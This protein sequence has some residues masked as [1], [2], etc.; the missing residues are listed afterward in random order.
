MSRGDDEIIAVPVASHPLARKRK[1]GA[2]ALLATE[3]VML[4]E[5][6]DTRGVV[7]QAYATR[8]FALVPS[9]VVDSQEAI[10]RLLRIG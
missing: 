5:A 10:K 7:A 6:S 2:T 1:L 3:L 9:L 8:G 4:E